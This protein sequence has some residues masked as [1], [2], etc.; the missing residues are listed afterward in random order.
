[1]QA[2][3]CVFHLVTP[4]QLVHFN[5]VRWHRDSATQSGPTGGSALF[6]LLS[7]DFC[8]LFFYP[9]ISPR[10]R[11]IAAKYCRAFSS[12]RS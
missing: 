4:S 1:M 11:A 3:G 5:S 7:S 10:A 9:A 2:A 12:I 6:C 8:L